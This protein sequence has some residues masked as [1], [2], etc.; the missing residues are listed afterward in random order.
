VFKQSSITK[1]LETIKEC[2]EIFV[3]HASWEYKFD[4]IIDIYNLTLES[5]L[6]SAGFILFWFPP[7]VSDEEDI[8]AFMDSLMNLKATIDYCYQTEIQA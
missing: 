5:S 2:E 8:K 6:I 3:S 1:I 7:N 4:K